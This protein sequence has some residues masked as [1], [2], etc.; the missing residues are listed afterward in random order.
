[1]TAASPR[2]LGRALP[3]AGEAADMGHSIVRDG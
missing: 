3:D 1:M 2:R